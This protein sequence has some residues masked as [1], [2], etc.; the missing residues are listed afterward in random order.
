MIPGGKTFPF[1]NICDFLS[2]EIKKLVIFKNHLIV[3]LIYNEISY[4]VIKLINILRSKTNKV[5]ILNK[6]N[7]YIH[8]IPLDNLFQEKN[9][10]D[11]RYF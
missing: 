6:I 7:I 8:K 5:N 9:V 11:H 2:K 10:N 4:I 3:F 1:L